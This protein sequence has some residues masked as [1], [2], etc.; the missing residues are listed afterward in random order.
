MRGIKKFI[1]QPAYLVA[2]FFI[3]LYAL[4]SSETLQSPGFARYDEFLTLARTRSMLETGDFFAVYYNGEPNMNK[5]PLQYWMGAG[6]IRL[7]LSEERGL[8]F[9][10]LM[11][12]LGT[13]ILC[14]L[15]ACQLRGE[16]DPW[17]APAAVGFLG[18]SLLFAEHM[19]TGMLETGLCFFVVAA[20]YSLFRAL[21]RPGWW[22]VWGFACGLGALQKAPMAIL[23]SLVCFSTLYWGKADKLRQLV[24]RRTFWAGIVVQGALTGFWPLLQTM[25][26][27]SDY[28]ETSAKEGF[29]RFTLGVRDHGN[30]EDFG[31]H[32]DRLL[33]PIQ[34][35]S[36]FWVVCAF[37]VLSAL[38]W[39]REL[40]RDRRVLGIIGFAALGF[41]IVFLAAGPIHHRYILVFT[42]PMVAFTAA[43]LSQLSDRAWVAPAM[44]FFCLT[45]Q[46]SR[47]PEIPYKESS[48]TRQYLR[49]VSQI[50][51]EYLKPGEPGLTLVP[52]FQTPV[53]VSEIPFGKQSIIRRSH[54]LDRPSY[55]AIVYYPVMDEVEKQFEILEVKRRLGEVWIVVVSPRRKGQLF[56]EFYQPRWDTE[57]LD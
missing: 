37:T 7:G 30:V 47:L 52:R 39:K 33:F 34:D 10:P 50:Y 5:P 1:R 11:F 24:R 41:L 18:S 38:L 23:A 16:E 32:L 9:S 42:P 25:R 55:P 36:M 35:A 57:Y 45:Y 14:A 29:H 49:A 31:P 53:V 8:R 22:I 3:L 27:G 28:L 43:G 15:L 56:G 40:L 44:A 12:G 4:W 13:F 21:E 48:R 51:V 2:L 17:V 26:F 6:L 46:S 20:I 54:V 19:R